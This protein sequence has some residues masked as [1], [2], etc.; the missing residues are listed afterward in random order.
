[1]L[2][3][4]YAIVRKDGVISGARA[5]LSVRDGIEIEFTDGTV[6]STITDM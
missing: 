1:V 6:R 5:G 3:R 4:G 2:K